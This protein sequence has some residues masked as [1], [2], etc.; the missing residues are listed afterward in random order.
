MDYGCA[1]GFLTKA[2]NYLGIECHGYD[3]SEWAISYGKNEV[4]KDITNVFRYNQE[5]TLICLDVLEHM[6]LKDVNSILK[7]PYKKLIVRIPVEAKDNEGFYLEESK[8]DQTHITCMTKKRWEI[9]FR[10][11]GFVLMRKL[12][13]KTIWDSK[14]VLSRIYVR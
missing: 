6:S 3:V 4:T 5:K 7:L 8:C 14:G 9:F 11:H 1:V 12:H 13:K 10:E 2:I